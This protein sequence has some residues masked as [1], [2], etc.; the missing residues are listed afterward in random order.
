MN[1][2]SRQVYLKDYIQTR[3]WGE[4]KGNFF[5]V[6][7]SFFVSFKRQTSRLKENQTNAVPSSLFVGMGWGRK[8]VPQTLSIQPPLPQI[9]AAELSPRTWPQSKGTQVPGW[10]G[11]V[12][13][14]GE[15][16][17]AGNWI[18]GK[19]EEGDRVEPLHGGGG[20]GEEPGA[21]WHP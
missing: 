20:G 17:Q 11:D 5:L 19:K 18:E 21:G 6:N 12:A 16:S 8:Q 4:G 15:Q 3:I 2:R 9:P 1:T 7:F 14:P 10:V 13:E